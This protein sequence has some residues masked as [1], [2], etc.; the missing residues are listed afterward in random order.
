M[1]LG[2]ISLLV[3]VLGIGFLLIS[4]TLGDL[5]QALGVVVL[6]LVLLTSLII[7]GVHH[8]FGYLA[9]W[10]PVASVIPLFGFVSAWRSRHEGFRRP[11][12]SD[13]SWW[14]ASLVALALVWAL[15]YVVGSWSLLVGLAYLVAL[16]IRRRRAHGASTLRP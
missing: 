6:G 11:T 3:L 10:I 4:N 14:A 7:D 13:W 1:R 5:F 16:A 8:G 12:R 15:G 2:V 9:I